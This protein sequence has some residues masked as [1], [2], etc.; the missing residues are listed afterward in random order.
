MRTKRSTRAAVVRVLKSMRDPRRQVNAVVICSTFLEITMTKPKLHLVFLML[1][2]VGCAPTSEQ[3]QATNTATSETQAGR[4][5]FK[6]SDKTV[7]QIV[8]H[9]AKFLGGELEILVPATFT[10]MDD[11]TLK[12]KYPNENRPT[13]VLTNDTGSIN[14]AIN[15][16]NN[17]VAASQL[18]QLHQQ[19][20]ISI[21]QAQP[22]ASWMFSGFQHHHGREWTQ[23]EFQ[24]QAID[25][26]IHNIMIATS[27]GGRMLAIS[28][29]CTDEHSAEWLSVGREIVNSCLVNGK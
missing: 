23:L 14:L 6:Q 25:T 9:P 17:A 3:S 2:V 28:F 26:K 8:L 12:T 21:R 10:E 20:D 1:F 27:V 19:L 4:G 29:N 15:H 24:S 13:L 5:S 22:N 11:A 16:S 7:G 18:K